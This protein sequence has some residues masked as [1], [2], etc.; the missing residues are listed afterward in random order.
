MDKTGS[1]YS[2]RL[3][4]LRKDLEKTWQERKEAIAEFDSII[5]QGPGSIPAPDGCLRIHQAGA[6]LNR[7]I[8]AHVQ[9]AKRYVDLLTEH[10]MK[11]GDA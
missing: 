5:Q 11:F 9:V 8:D 2:I 3:E 6:R 10:S 1:T 4:L 7:A